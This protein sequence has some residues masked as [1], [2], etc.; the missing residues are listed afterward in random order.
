MIYWKCQPNAN[1]LHVRLLWG[2]K[3]WC[4]VLFQASC[5]IEAK[6]WMKRLGWKGV[7]S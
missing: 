7:W 5:P 6:T 3:A 2:T 4:F 1:A